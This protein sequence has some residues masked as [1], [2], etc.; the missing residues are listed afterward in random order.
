[1]GTMSI[2][3]PSGQPN[4]WQPQPMT[5]LEMSQSIAHLKLVIHWLVALVVANLLLS[6]YVAR[7]VYDVLQAVNHL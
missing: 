2:S 1:V 5:P 6:A 3:N 7:F 4:Q